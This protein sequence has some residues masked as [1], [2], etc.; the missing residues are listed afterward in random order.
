MM[1][2]EDLIINQHKTKLTLVEFLK[3]VNFN[4]NQY[5]KD[6]F[7]FELNTLKDGEF[8]EVTDDI[9]EKIGYQKGTKGNDRT[10]LFRFIKNNFVENIEYKTTLLSG[11]VVSTNYVTNKNKLEMTRDSFKMLLLQVN[12]T[13]SKEIYRYFIDYEKQ[14]LRFMIY[15]NELKTIENN[16][17]KN[18][19]EQAIPPP[20]NIFQQNMLANM[21]IQ[22]DIYIITSKHYAR[23]YLFKVGRTSNCKQR[24]SSMNTSHVLDDDEMYICHVSTCFDSHNCEKRIHALLESVRYR[25]DR[26][27]FLIPFQLLVELVSTVAT[28]FDQHNEKLNDII[29]RL[30]TM[31]LPATCDFIPDPIVTIETSI[32]LYRGRQLS[33]FHVSSHSTDQVRT[34][35]HHA[36]ELYHQQYPSALMYWVDFQKCIER[37]VSPHKVKFSEWKNFIQHEEL[38]TAMKWRKCA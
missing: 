1:Q 10:H 16:D 6:T 9:I 38:Y 12:T 17:L 22:E 26:E 4:P 27:F 13:T 3:E 36:S 14:T 8:F 20:L 33:T 19:I 34:Y 21:D 29:E 15:Q 11:R 25:Q 23:N 31:V 35:L 7:W 24:L 5:F 30:T 32:H 37:A 18:K 28:S 2:F